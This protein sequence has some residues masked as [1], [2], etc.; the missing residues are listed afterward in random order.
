MLSCLRVSTGESYNAIMHD[1]QVQPPYC[2]P[3][4]GGAVDPNAGN[5]GYKEVAPLLFVA[6]MLGI[7]YMLL[8]L[9]IAVI[10]DNFMETQTMSE[11]K[12]TD[13]HFASFDETW[14]MYDSTGDQYISSNL[15]PALITQVLY[16]LGLKGVP[17]GHIHGSTIRRHAKKMTHQL[18]CQ[19][20][21]G[22][23]AWAALRSALNAHAMGDMELP[24]EASVVQE[25][26]RL[27][28][29]K[30]GAGVIRKIQTKIKKDRKNS[31]LVTPKR[32]TSSSGDRPET[33]EGNKGVMRVSGEFDSKQYTL[34]HVIAV[35]STQ[36]LV[37]GN[38]TRKTLKQWRKLTEYAKVKAI[39]PSL[40]TRHQLAENNFDMLKKGVNSVRQ[41]L[42][43]GKLA[44]T[45]RLRVMMKSFNKSQL[46]GSSK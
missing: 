2:D 21:H 32:A 22:M 38:N 4:V 26:K 12:V 15:V 42:K 27:H 34:S 11:S 6:V 1:C 9:L 5:C 45:A 7:N 20:V 39:H 40:R 3:F 19:V 18:N 28:S 37:R 29:R 16:P 14:S 41:R 33:D 30:A 31:V 13:E 36:S 46:S 17:L 8:N 23:V 25:L 35:I 10:L 43:L 24:E 44:E